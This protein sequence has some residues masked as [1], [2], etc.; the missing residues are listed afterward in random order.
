MAGYLEYI[1][2]E[3]LPKHTRLDII[4]SNGNHLAFV[5]QRKLGKVGFADNVEKYIADHDIGPDALSEHWSMDNF[6]SL[7]KGRNTDIKK[8]LM[9]QKHIS[10]IGNVYA[11]E[12]LYQSGL[13]P[14]RKAKEL[15]NDEISRL[16]R[17]ML[18]VL[19]TAID[20]HA[21]P[22]KMPDSWILPRRKEGA[23]CTRCSGKVKKVKVGGRSSYLC[24]DCQN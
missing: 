15:D 11:D 13:R 16:H 10:G 5:C 21:D 2:G 1:E 9:D 7:I 6:T 8:V 4:F 3:D 22:E 23:D 20:R 14:A 19:K 18:H 12:I 24:P 17:A